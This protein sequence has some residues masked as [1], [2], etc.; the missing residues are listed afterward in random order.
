M[1]PNPNI[2]RRIVINPGTRTSS[3]I[4][5]IWIEEVSTGPVERAETEDSLQITAPDPG[6]QSAYYHRE[7]LAISDLKWIEI[8]ADYYVANSGDLSIIS[9]NAHNGVSVSQIGG[10][11]ATITPTTKKILMLYS[12]DEANLYPAFGFLMYGGQPAIAIV[13]NITFTI[14]S[15]PPA[16]QGVG[17]DYSAGAGSAATTSSIHANHT[18]AWDSGSGRL[19]LTATGAGTSYITFAGPFNNDNDSQFLVVSG[20]TASGSVEI[21][22][23]LGASISGVSLSANGQVSSCQNLSN[24]S[25]EI[26]LKFITTGAGDIYVEKWGYGKHRFY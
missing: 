17:R 10:Y 4:V 1:A 12:E 6:V 8:E 2:I 13:E 18:L 21:C 14:L 16:G 20:M 9:V 19:K 25:V 26:G 23:E 24:T 5:Y 22:E 15:E 3:P 7:D 11:S